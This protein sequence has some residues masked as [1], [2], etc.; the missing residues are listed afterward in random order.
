MA[1]LAAALLAL[2][3]FDRLRA[4]SEP[5]RRL[6]A[7][8][9]LVMVVLGLALTLGVAL[10]D[11]FYPVTGGLTVLSDLA[12]GYYGAAARLPDTATA[13]TDHVARAEN[14]AVPDRVRTHPPGP[15]LF[16]GALR[17]AG[18]L[19]HGSLDTVEALLRRTYGVDGAQL[20]EL[21]RPAVAETPSPLEA[22]IAV[23]VAFLLAALSA[24]IVL[25]VYAL[26]AALADRRLGLAG[27]VLALSL[28]ALVCYVPGIDGPGAVLALTALALWAG[29]LRHGDWWRYLLA[30]LGVAVALLWSFGYAVLAIPA[31]VLMFPRDDWRPVRLGPGLIFAAAGLG[32][33]YGG[34]DAAFGYSLPAALSASLDAQREIMLREQRPYL[35]WL[36]LNPYSWA[37][38]AGPGLLL[39]GVAGWCAKGGA[40][41]GL[42]RTLQGLAVTLVVLILA[43]TTRAE[44]ERI[45]VFL[46]PLAGLPAAGLLLRF[47]PT[48]RLWAPTLL[49]LAQV[50]LALALRGTFDLVKPY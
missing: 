27:A 49:V 32:V 12:I 23:P 17:Q 13:F 41:G 39:L 48:L 20:A 9:L 30:G 14:P 42:G 50:A 40:A 2:L 5:S 36:W 11:P 35:T 8:L 45:W 38:F 22:L 29:A 46:M 15:I 6:S 3:T 16:L 25:P 1:L 18:L 28:P 43:G 33:V 26:G 19:G 4:A 34:L 47:P 44:V 21:A 7:L 10:H 24:L 37:I 31:F